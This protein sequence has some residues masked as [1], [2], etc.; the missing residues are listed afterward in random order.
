MTPEEQTLCVVW[1]T[2][3]DECYYHMWRVR[4]KNERG[5]D[6]GFHLQN[7]K[8]ANQ[9]VELLNK[10]DDA[11]STVTEQRDRLATIL[12]GIRFEYR[13]QIPDPTCDCGDCEF[14]ITMDNALQYLTK[15]N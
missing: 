8:E 11:L 4:R 6:D 13:G 9:L 5:F 12:Q 1:E 15:P 10:Q 3:C 7:G 14:L 2:Y